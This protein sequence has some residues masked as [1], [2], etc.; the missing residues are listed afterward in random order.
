MI[1]QGS[2]V[3]IRIPDS[4]EKKINLFGKET[5]LALTDTLSQPA[6]GSIDSLEPAPLSPAKSILSTYSISDSVQ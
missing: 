2:Q 6:Q 3:P 4:R 1:L 5:S